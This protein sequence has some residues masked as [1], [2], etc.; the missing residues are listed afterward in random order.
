MTVYVDDA[1]NGF[2][3]MVM[4]HMLADTPEELHAMASAVG[5]K[6]QWY[7]S[8]DKASFPHYDLSLTRRA[9]AVAKGAKEISRK[10]CGEYMRVTKNKLIT[11]GETW[12]S[13]GWTILPQDIGLCVTT[14]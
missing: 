6:W 14:G 9:L 5:L 4:C 12:A 3:R 1:R 13:A 2:S 8:P 11:Q 7:Q 10:E